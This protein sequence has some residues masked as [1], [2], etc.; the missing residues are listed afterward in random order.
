LRIRLVTPIC[1]QDKDFLTKNL[2]E[3][4]AKLDSSEDNLRR[5]QNQLEQVKQAREELYEKYATS[6][7]EARVVYERRL[8][9]EL[10][11]IRYVTDS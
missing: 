4:S 7:D 8:Q 11:R 3:T 1:V 6:R 5:A 2:S 10:D 9:T